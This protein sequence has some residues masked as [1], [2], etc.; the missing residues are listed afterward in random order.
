[1]KDVR[2]LVK[3]VQTGESFCFGQIAECA[4][5]FNLS[6]ST[7]SNRIKNGVLTGRRWLFEYADEKRQAQIKKR[8]AASKNGEK[9]YMNKV[10]NFLVAWKVAAKKLG[11]S[12]ERL[13][14]I[15]KK[16]GIKGYLY[17]DDV[18]FYPR[19][20]YK[21]KDIKGIKEELE[22]KHNAAL[23][24]VIAFN[25]NINNGRIYHFTN[26][27]VCRCVLKKKFGAEIPIEVMHKLLKD[28][29]EYKGWYIDEEA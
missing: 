19:R 22:L 10:P 8:A 11:I 29:N 20:Y 6:Q 1:M 14:A 17:V 24:A 7:V 3:D 16:K 18:S 5:H 2:V 23:K 12:P 26:I 9:I 13:Y 15:V 25:K 4:R 27:Y 28:G 21:W